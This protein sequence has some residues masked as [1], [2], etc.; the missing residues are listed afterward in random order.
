[1]DQDV[2]Q[3]VA[4]NVVGVKIVVQGKTD[5]SYWTSGGKAFKPCLRN[6]L[7]GEL[8]KANVGIFHNVAN[9]IENKRPV[10]RV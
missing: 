7:K 10:E 5:S 4:Q 1:M 2:N 9:I 6:V 3:T 8:C